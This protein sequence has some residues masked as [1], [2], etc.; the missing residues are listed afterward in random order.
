M[1][2][3]LQVRFS[4]PQLTRILEEAI[5]YMCACP[6][7]VAKQLLELRNL[8]VYQRRDALMLSLDE[9]GSGSR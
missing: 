5:I 3:S 8:F 9:D 1:P 6:A 7:Q 4:D 2:D